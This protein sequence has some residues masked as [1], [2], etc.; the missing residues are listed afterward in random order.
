MEHTTVNSRGTA[1]YRAPELLAPKAAYTNKVDIWALGCITYE[2][3]N[4]IRAFHDDWAVMRYMSDSSTLALDFKRLPSNS[5]FAPRE[6][7]EIAKSLLATDFNHRPLWKST[8]F[9][10]RIGF[11][12]CC[13]TPSK[14]IGVARF[15]SYCEPQADG[16]HGTSGWWKLVQDNPRAP[17][18]RI[19]LATANERLGDSKKAI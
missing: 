17:K 13:Y 1:S 9:L 14:K 8:D 10:L 3:M 7:F 2:L 5:A 4:A 6:L 16:D 11:G 19:E 15:T 12:L 18:A